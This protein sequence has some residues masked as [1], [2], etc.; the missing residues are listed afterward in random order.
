M[1]K[2]KL[3]VV[4][5]TGRWGRYGAAAKRAREQCGNKLGNLLKFDGMNENLPMMKA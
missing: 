2:R 1:T 5:N 4:G 3:V